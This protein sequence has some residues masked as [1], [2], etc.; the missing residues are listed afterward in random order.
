MLY[1]N[2]RG[3]ELLWTIIIRLMLDGLAAWKAIFT[4]DAGFFIA[5]CKAHIHF[6][7]WLLFEKKAPVEMHNK[8]VKITGLYHGSIVWDYFIKKKKTFREIV[9]NK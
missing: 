2:L 1:K 7:A 3:L 6:T 9:D 4:G 5:V 8:K